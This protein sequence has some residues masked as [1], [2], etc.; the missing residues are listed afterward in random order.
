MAT[1]GSITVRGTATRR[2]TPDVA[3]WS[4]VV[5]GRAK[6]EREAFGA[7]SEAL[8]KLFETVRAG[9]KDA[10]VAT[11]PVRV[12]PEWNETGRK[13]IGYQASAAVTIRG[14]LDEAGGLAQAALDA[15]ATRLDGPEFLIGELTRIQDELA[16]DAVDAARDRA[17]RMA[18]AADRSL[19]AVLQITDEGV[20]T[21]YAQV[22]YE[23]KAMSLRGAADVTAPPTAPQMQDIQTTAVVTF[24]LT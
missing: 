16:A 22:A 7:C 24:A 15:G 2:V 3:I 13:R 17:T 5:E 10:E 12:W 1:A 4:A 21:M 18:G 19:G 23:M 20:Q 6:T 9:A 8:T 11:D 14:P